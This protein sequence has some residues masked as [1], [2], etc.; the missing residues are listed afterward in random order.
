M[1]KCLIDPGEYHLPWKYWVLSYYPSTHNRINSIRETNYCCTVG[2]RVRL[3]QF[4]SVWPENV[5]DYIDS[6]TI[7]WEIVEKNFERAWKAHNYCVYKTKPLKCRINTSILNLIR[8]NECFTIRK[9]LYCGHLHWKIV[10]RSSSSPNI[11][12]FLKN[13]MVNEFVNKKFVDGF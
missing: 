13:S 7:Y 3:I 2:I 6:I 10:Q 11:A 9:K 5:S 4:S 8:S 1:Q 12:K